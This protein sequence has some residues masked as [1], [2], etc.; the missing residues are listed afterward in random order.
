MP[1]TLISVSTRG[2]GLY[3]FTEAATGFVRSAGVKTGLLTL[4]VRH[5]SCSLLIQEN[6]DP[7]VRRDLTAFFRRLVPPSNDPSM[8]W[9][10][11]TTEGPD[12]MP[13]HV[14]A[15]LTAVSIGI[16][17]IDGALALGTWQGIYLFEHRDRPHRRDVVLHL[18]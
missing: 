1:Q 12:D 18:S 9:M 2:Q 10:V 16:P 7:D 17:I 15:A 4:F 5:T 3:E 6:A 11:H 8:Q 13:A 14:K